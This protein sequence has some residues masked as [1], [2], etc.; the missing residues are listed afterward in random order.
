M[1]SKIYPL[2]VILA[3]FFW[4]STGLFVRVLQSYGLDSLQISC[5]RLITAAILMFL[6]VLIKD[7]KLLKI[8]PKDLWMFLLSG[9]FSVFFTC[10]FY[11][12]TISLASVSVACILM[13]TAPIFVIIT[14][15]FAFGEKLTKTKIS[16]MIIAFFGCIFVSGIIGSD[17]KAIS[18]A[19]FLFGLGSGIAY[20]SYSIFSKIALKKYSPYT[21]TFYSF[22]IAGIAAFFLADFSAIFNIAAKNTELILLYP[23]TGLFVS[24]VPFL[25]YTLGLSGMESGPA[26]VLSCTEPLV[27]ALVSIFI[28]S[29][30]FSVSS[31]CGIIMI[32]ISIIML[33]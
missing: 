9:G 21:V 15:F 26:C 14:S 8:N 25:L 24:V 11:F 16:A 1:K 28:L 30:P 29:E 23:M 19:G 2:F 7:K 32:L 18:P 22:L 5:I 6:F 17:T 4:G 10:I 20:A 33:R 12:K 3:G 31:V 27:A 13:Y